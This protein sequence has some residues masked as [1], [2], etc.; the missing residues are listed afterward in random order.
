M[1]LSALKEALLSYMSESGIIFQQETNEKLKGVSYSRLS[2]DPAHPSVVVRG[3]FE[4]TFWEVVTIAHEVGHVLNFGEM[5]LDEAR[6]FFCTM[7]AATSL[8]LEKLS[9]GGKDS[10]CTPRL[11][12]PLEVWKS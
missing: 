8:G 11:W 5:G 3:Q 4:D 9:S 2:L 7:F 10:R 12:L 1:E 6:E